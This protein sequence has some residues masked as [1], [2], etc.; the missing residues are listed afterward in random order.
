MSEGRLGAE[1]LRQSDADAILP[2]TVGTILWFVAVLALVVARVA[3]D[4][5]GTT[6][7]I[8]VAAV[9]LLSGL[10]GIAYLRWRKGRAKQAA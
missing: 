10:G 5:E 3:L 7:W 4:V 6:W 9:G 2:V 1:R 8:G